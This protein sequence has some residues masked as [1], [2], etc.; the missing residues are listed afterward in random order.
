VR[1]YVYKESVLV[2]LTKKKKLSNGCQIGTA[3]SQLVCSAECR[4]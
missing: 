4:E 3:Y 2:C 1:I